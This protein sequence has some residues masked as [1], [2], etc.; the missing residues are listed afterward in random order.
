MSKKSRRRNRMLAAMVGLAGASKLGLL[1]KSPIGNQVFMKQPQ[2][3]EK[4][5]LL[6]LQTEVR[7]K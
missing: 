3:L 1:S 6:L 2:K 7:G 4:Q 5:E